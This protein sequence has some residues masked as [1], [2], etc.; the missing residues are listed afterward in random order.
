MAIEPVSGH[1]HEQETK[2]KSARP[3]ERVFP[4]FAD[5][6][7][8]NLRTAQRDLQAG[9]TVA[10][11]AVP[12]ALAFAVL[13]GVP[14]V[15]GLYAAVVMSV[16]AALM[17]SSPYVNTGPTNSAALLTASAIG[18]WLHGAH[19][20]G[21][22]A[23]F[24]LLVGVVRLALGIFRMGRL[25]RFVPEPAFLGFGLG[26]G[27]LIA[28]GQIHHVFGVPAGH[29]AAPLAR[30]VDV[31]RHVSEVNWPSAAIALGTLGFMVL[32]RRLRLRLPDALVAMVVSAVVAWRL[33]PD[34][35]LVLVGDLARIPRGLPAVGLPPLDPTMLMDMLPSAAAV[36]VLGLIEA[37][38][39]GHTI[40]VRRRESM[41]FDQEFIGQGLSQLVGS[42]F[43]TM[44]GSGSFSRSLLMEHAGA[45]TR[46]ANV[47][48]GLF[49]AVAVLAMP[50]LLERIPVSALAGVLLYISYRLFD[51][52]R[53]RRVR[54]TS[55]ADAAVLL[56]TFA[57]TIFIRIE[58]GIFAGIILAAFLH[59]NRECAAKMA[60]LVPGES[61][62]Y[63]EIPY[64]QGFIHQPSSVVAVTLSGDLFYGMAPSLRERL[65]DI[66]RRQ[67]PQW[68]ILRLRRTSFI[69]YSCWSL[70]QDVASNLRGN[71]GGMYLCGVD[72]HVLPMIRRDPWAELF[73][74][75]HIFPQTATP[76]ASFEACVTAVLEG[77]VDLSTLSPAWRGFSNKPGSAAPDA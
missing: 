5:V 21:A 28:A 30:V 8:Y 58:Y 72:P 29:A 68:L 10:I 40:A 48:F 3:L 46:F 2:G 59:L 52:D 55:R 62:S 67:Q 1:L 19:G 14:P 77:T 34:S 12:Q 11:F 64:A 4:F 22:V 20:L 49:T 65:D 47:A 35:G 69:D 13:A 74:D 60:E 75:E 6:R 27:L 17:G 70:L 15:H 44:P 26:A 23:A 31:M 37:A 54:R 56:A 33:G 71:R 51:L 61:G 76:Y 25:L 16:V 41:D 50:G 42:L 24:T 63:Q 32:C 57:V 66:V 36:A 45:A 18:P 43:P 7:G 73:P 39:I 53:I 38:L 9:L